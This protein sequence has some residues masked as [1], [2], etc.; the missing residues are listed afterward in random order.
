MA[1]AVA[2]DMVT[3]FG[4]AEMLRLTAP[5]G[6]PLDVIDLDAVNAALADASAVIDSYLRRRYATPV[7][8]VPQE[9]TRACCILARFDLAHG[10]A[11]NPTAQMSVARRE[12]IAW[13]GELRDGTVLLADA[14]PAG[15]QSF[16]QVRDAGCPVFGDP[17]AD[18]FATD[19]A[20]AFWSGGL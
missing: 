9:L 15:G 6:Q 12:T 20:P 7:T 19:P 13:L 5:E 2:Q 18:S 14:T 4:Q 11:T 8:P 16:G 10:D 1:Y 3:R 17:G